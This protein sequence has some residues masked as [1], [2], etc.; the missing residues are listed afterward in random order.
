MTTLLVFQNIATGRILFNLIH[1]G[2]DGGELFLFTACGSL[3][4]KG[5]DLVAEALWDFEWPNMEPSVRRDFSFMLM[6]TKKICRIS[7]LDWIPCSVD[8]LR[9]VVN[10]SFN[11]FAVL[12]NIA[13]RK[14]SGGN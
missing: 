14:T 6:R 13:R 5:N 10:A 1:I 7:F 3:I 11:M 12:Q 4:T 2:I 8:S 9:F